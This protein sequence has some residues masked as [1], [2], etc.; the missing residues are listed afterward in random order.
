MIYDDLLFQLVILSS[1]LV[2]TL[3]YPASHAGEDHMVMKRQVVDQQNDQ[4]ALFGQVL[5]SFS[6]L[7]S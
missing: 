6:K 7:F 5:G 2:V 4:F 1:I 3:F